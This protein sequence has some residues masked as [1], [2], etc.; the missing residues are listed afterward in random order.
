MHDIFNK[1]ISELK[2]E[3]GLKEARVT[4]VQNNSVDYSQKTVYEQYLENM[5][6]AEEGT[7]IINFVGAINL[8]LLMAVFFFA[9][10]RLI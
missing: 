3:A 6:L 9:I 1:E 7:E 4:P 10:I 8:I 2:G 5:A